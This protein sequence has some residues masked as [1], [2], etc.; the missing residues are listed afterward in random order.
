MIQ[1]GLKSTAL[2][3][4]EWPSGEM[5]AAQMTGPDS[6][7]LGTMPV[8]EPIPGHALVK[9]SHVGLCA[10][11]V[12]LFRG[13]STYIKKGYVRYPH[14]FGHEFSGTIVATTGEDASRVGEPIVA[15]SLIACG[16]CEYCQRGYRTGCTNRLEPGI[17]GMDGGAA[18]Y[19]RLP[20]SA[21]LPLPEGVGL[22]EAPLIEPSVVVSHVFARVNPSFDDRVAVIGTGTLGLVAVQ[23]AAKVAAEVH[24]IGI[25]EAGLELALESGAD[26][27]CEPDDAPSDHYSVVI[28]V[29]GAPASWELFPRIATPGARVALAGMVHQ[30]VN[31]LTPSGLTL[32]DLTMEAVLDGIDHYART[33]KLLET[34]VVQP[35]VLIEEVVPVTQ[36]QEALEKLVARKQRRPKILLSWDRLESEDGDE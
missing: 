7:E 2:T 21:C 18:E 20:L 13:T 15:Q 5:R 14:V 34:G 26:R 24:A 12:N 35:R 17:R 19:V 4:G 3:Q 1:S 31:G 22:E 6:V 10:T 27:A 29:A 32:K 25:E 33:I 8:P 30:E 11:D 36:A 23:V 28:E 9:T 16:E